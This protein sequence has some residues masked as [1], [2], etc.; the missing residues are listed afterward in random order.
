MCGCSSPLDVGWAYCLACGRPTGFEK[1][2]GDCG[3]GI[4]PE[5]IEAAIP[6]L[7]RAPRSMALLSNGNAYRFR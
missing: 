4:G 1:V 6:V 7:D 3:D 5:V 2:A